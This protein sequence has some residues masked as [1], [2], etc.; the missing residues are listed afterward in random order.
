M[1]GFEISPFSSFPGILVSY[2]QQGDYHSALFEHSYKGSYFC[3]YVAIPK[4]HKFFGMYHD[5]FNET[6]LPGLTY[7]EQ[8]GSHWVLGFDTAGP[9]QN[10]SESDAK[11]ILSS[12]NSYLQK[13]NQ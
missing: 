6:D 12:L 11:S 1:I 7:S 8:Q 13:N 4:R 3:G 2:Y 5:E 9:F 10:S